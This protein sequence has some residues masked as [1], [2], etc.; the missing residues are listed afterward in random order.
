[1]I[2]RNT[3]RTGGPPSSDSDND[4]DD[5]TN[6][7]IPKLSEVESMCI[8][9]IK[10]ELSLNTKSCSEKALNSLI[11]SQNEAYVLNASNIKQTILARKCVKMEYR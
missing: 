2:D 8:I 10:G 9:L 7:E 6:L 1:M 3:G 11:S 5:D 4:E